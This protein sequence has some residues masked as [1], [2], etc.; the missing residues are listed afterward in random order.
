MTH[1]VQAPSFPTREQKRPAAGTVIK[2]GSARAARNPEF[3]EPSVEQSLESRLKGRGAGP[4]WENAP[5]PTVQPKGWREKARQLL[6]RRSYAPGKEEVMSSPLVFG[7]GSLIIV[8]ALVGVK[9]YRVI[10]DTAATRLFDQAVENLNDGDYRN[11]IARFDEFIKGNPVDKRI[12]KARV[13]RAMANVRQYASATG[14]SWSNALEAEREMFETVASEPEYQDSSAELD[15][16]VLKTGEALADRA[17]TAADQKSLTDADA[18][19]A[20]HRRVGGKMAE[21]NLKK[22]RLS[23]KLDAAR[24]AVKK[25]DIRTKALADMDAAL[26]AD[27]SIGVYAARDALVETYSRPCRQDARPQPRG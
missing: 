6:S 16:L 18:A 9:L 13:H 12:G 3:A 4:N 15:Q 25:A 5:Q 20:L 17:K 2:R 21:T 24:A 7:L 14:V 11:S 26:K 1:Y 27:S 19:L 10:R 22:S 23:E 8:L